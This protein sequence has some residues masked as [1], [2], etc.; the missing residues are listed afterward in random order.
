MWYQW[1]LQNKQLEDW[2]YFTAKLLIHFHKKH[3][4]SQESRLWQWSNITN[5]SFLQNYDEQSECK[6]KMDAH[7]VFDQLLHKETDTFHFN[8]HLCNCDIDNEIPAHKHNMD[9]GDLA[10]KISANTSDQVSNLISPPIATT[11]IPLTL[12]ESVFEDEK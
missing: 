1:L 10:Q 2:K 12:M 9:V 7:K 11:L 6:G 4:A 3:L 8:E 5:S